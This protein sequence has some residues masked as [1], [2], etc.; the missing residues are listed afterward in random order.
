MKWSDIKKELKDLDDSELFG[1]LKD[2]YQLSP[3]NK[4]FFQSRF[5]D[6]EAALMPY[7][8]TIESIFDWRKSRIDLRKGKQAITEYS[9]AAPDDVFGKVHLMLR[10]VEMGTAF[11][12]EYGDMEESY[13]DSMESV[14]D[15]ITK[16]AEKLDPNQYRECANRIDSLAGNAYGRVGYG[17]AD[18]LAYIAEELSVE[19]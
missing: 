1:L 8:T 3:A 17:Y 5:G 12:L 9:K 11:T 2:L 10:Y 6:R 4:R 19:T 7:I 16:V 15:E 14:L 18:Y 13:Y